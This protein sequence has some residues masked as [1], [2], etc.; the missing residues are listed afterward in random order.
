[1]GL[2][3][4][5]DV[6]GDIVEQFDARDRSVRDVEVTTDQDRAGGLGV[7]M[8]V[9][10]S[11]CA[12]SSDGAGAS[13]TPE[14]AAISENGG[15]TVTVS[16]ADLL[17]DLAA[18]E[19]VV[20]V[21]EEAVHVEDGDLVMTVSFRVVPTASAE[22]AASDGDRPRDS[23]AETAAVSTEGDDSLA[24]RLA[25]AR[26]DDVPPYEDTAYLQRLYD[27]CGTFTEMSEHIEMDVAAETVRRYM[28]EADIHDPTSYDTRESDDDTDGPASMTDGAAT[29]AEDGAPDSAPAEADREPSPAA[30]E[31][32]PDEQFVTD[33]I[34]LPDGVHV[35]D[36]VDA[37]VDA[38][39]VYEVERAL[40][41]GREQ[42]RDLLRQLN[43]LD[44]VLHRIDGPQRDA[45]KNDVVQRIRQC[46][47]GDA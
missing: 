3:D 45:S 47:T 44:F 14:R 17:P 13:L 19:T 31:P 43:L 6:L 4:S 37:V 25:A 8:T 20:G 5:F 39:A 10:V 26:S 27:S 2:Q 16:A 40:D 30:P 38:T 1:M 42:T 18:T 46:A 24:A 9:P 21:D 35:E 22:T 36:I 32:V 41:L 29:A 23:G 28:I 33:G 7:T 12:A 34:G 15:L 11:L